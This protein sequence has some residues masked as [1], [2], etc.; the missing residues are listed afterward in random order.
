[1]AIVA[2]VDLLTTRVMQRESAVGMRKTLGA[3]RGKLMMQLLFESGEDYV[4]PEHR[5]G[6]ARAGRMEPI[7]VAVK[8]IN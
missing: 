5:Y 7:R 8:K 3:M 6:L 4:R 2:D 1:V